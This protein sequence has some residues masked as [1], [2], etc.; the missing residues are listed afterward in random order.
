MSPSEV[1]HRATSLA[2]T[3]AEAVGIG[4]AGAPAPRLDS[5]P[6]RPW[7]AN[8]PADIDTVG[9]IAAANRIL[10]GRFDVFAMRSAALGFPPRW[11]VDPRT[12]R[13]APMAFGKAIDYRMEEL[14]G[15][16]KYLWEPA[17]HLEAVTLAQAWRVTG[18][19]RFGQGLV[20]LLESWFEQCPYP[21]GVHW[22]SS[23][24]LGIR[25]MNW[26][27]AWQLMGGLESSW[28]AGARGRAF[29]DRWLEAIYRHTHFV[30]HHTSRYSSANNHLIGEL[31]GLHVAACVWPFWQDVERWGRDA[32]QELEEQALAQNAPDGVNREQSVYYLHE[33]ADMMLIARH[34][35]VVAGRPMSEAFSARLL[36]MLEF[37]AAI[38]DSGG[39]V[40]MI[41]D[42]DDA[43]IVRFAPRTDDWCP[44]RSLLATG[45]VIFRRADFKDAA[46]SFDDKSRWL[47]GEGAERLFDELPAGQR[48]PARREFPE[49]GYWVLGGA[50][51]QARETRLVVDAGP[52][53]YLGIAAHGHADALAFTLSVAGNEVLID[54]GT[55]AYHTHKRWRDYFR[56]TAAHNTVR[57]DG[58]DQ[59]EIG[60]NF[61]WTHKAK[62]WCDRFE[63]GPERDVFVGA[64]DGYRRLAD[65]VTHRRTL[66]LD[67][68]AGVLLVNDELLCAGPHRAEIH[69][70]LSEHARAEL[71]PDGSVRIAAGS[72]EA[73]IAL[74]HRGEVPEILR[75]VD[76]PPLGWISRRFDL[77]EPT[78]T[79]RWTLSIAGTTRLSTR[80]EVRHH[81]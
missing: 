74:E 47:L 32:A 13:H 72:A 78:T 11:N 3:R 57:I 19:G 38:M 64:H 12:G 34:F 52:L 15:D 41:G 62:A 67:H 59:S 49:G 75:G 30:R 61:M 28:F 22:T 36:R 10:Q 43:Q 55:Y 46:R 44:Y 45:A 33:V 63:V 65:P 48:P 69:W 76:S 39:N 66:E 79:L 21:L 50:F 16:I 1:A 77:K 8:V 24:E 56:G 70:H 35:G 20:G 73:R 40:P 9:L 29:R 25:L 2:R 53:G 81:A 27:F 31:A 51:G 60:G 54:P 37:V 6:S 26:G 18:D 58:L 71:E 14:V 4:R 17:R 7:P 5:G 68:H 80:I 42:A 23:F